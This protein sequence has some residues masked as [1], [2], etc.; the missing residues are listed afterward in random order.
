M[1]LG[2]DHCKIVTLLPN[3]SV[4]VSLSTADKNSILDEVVVPTDRR[5]NGGVVLI[6]K[7]IENLLFFLSWC[8]GL[9]HILEVTCKT[10]NV[11][12]KKN[13]NVC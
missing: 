2:S 7:K 9:N 6:L 5:H 13:N 11:H 8:V 12:L 10:L 4:C 1:S 3:K